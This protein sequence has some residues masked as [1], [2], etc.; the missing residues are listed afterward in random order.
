MK[1]S[2]VVPCYNE[3]K[4]VSLFYEAVKND[5]SGVDFDY[6]LVFVNDGSKD[7]TFKELQKLCEGDLPVKI[8]NFSRNFG[9]ESAM[10][11]GLRES[12]GDYVTIIDA[13]LQQR[14]SIALDMVRML[15]GEPDYDCVAAYQESRRESK[16]LVFFKNSFYKLINKFSDTEFVQGASD[17]RTFRRPMVEAILA[18]DEYFRFSKGLFSWVGFNTKFIP[19]KVEERA[20]GNS[21]WSFK[22]LF[23]YALDGIFAFTTAPLRFATIIGLLTSFLSIVY[24]IVVVIQKLAFGIPVAGYATIVVLILLLGGIQLCCIGIIGEYIARTYIQTKGRPIYIA[25]QVIKNHKY[26]R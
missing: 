22:K 26:E 2:L 23:K 21:K 6:E 15:D 9:K 14:P 8:V 16:L 10:Y 24:L 5:F 12:E 4:N 11:A 20:T 25:K 13:D 18:M 3:E 19:Y 1:L 17:F 7:G